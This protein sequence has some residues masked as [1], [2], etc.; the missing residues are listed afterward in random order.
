VIAVAL[1]APLNA[2]VVPLP[3]VAGP[4]VPDMLKLCGGGV[5]GDV[6]PLTTPAQPPITEICGSILIKSKSKLQKEGLALRTNSSALPDF[7][8]S[9][10]V[11]PQLLR[12][13]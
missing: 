1:A 6:L 13:A 12:H 2:T 5:F 10:A 4:T 9:I 8:H 3:P 7:A 11:F